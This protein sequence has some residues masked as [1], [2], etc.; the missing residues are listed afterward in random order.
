MAS[1]IPSHCL[2]QSTLKSNCLCCLHKKMD[3][4]FHSRTCW[5]NVNDID[6]TRFLNHS[7]QLCTIHTSTAPPL[8]NENNFLLLSMSLRNCLCGRNLDKGEEN[9]I[10]VTAKWK[11]TH[12]ATCGNQ[13]SCLSR[14]F[15]LQICGAVFNSQQSAQM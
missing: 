5:R 1:N 13:S 2:Q 8:Y 14:M 9:S 10:N 6:M 15:T 3:I 4:F 11:L 12:V 7:V